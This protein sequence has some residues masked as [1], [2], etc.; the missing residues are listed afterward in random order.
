MDKPE[1]QP[2][3]GQL[4]LMYK[5]GKSTKHTWWSFK[6]QRESTCSTVVKLHLCAQPFAV[7]F[8]TDSKAEKI[9]NPFL[10]LIRNNRKMDCSVLGNITVNMP[11]VLVLMSINY[12]FRGAVIKT[13]GCRTFYYAWEVPLSLTLPQ[14]STIYSGEIE[15]ELTEDIGELAGTGGKSHLGERSSAEEFLNF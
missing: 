9:I 12:V 3:W 4:M 11:V 10:H 7:I 5:M 1:T 2:L 8:L 6:R 14:T 13:V 15:T